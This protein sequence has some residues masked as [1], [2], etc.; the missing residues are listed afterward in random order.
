MKGQGLSITTIVV[1]AIALLVLVVLVAIFTGN[2][3][4]TDK[5]LKSCE[6]TNGVCASE[7]PADGKS[8]IRNPAKD[9][10]CQSISGQED[11]K[12]YKLLEG[13]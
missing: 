10:I 7:K 4:E 2:I 9:A 12:C 8:Y 1:A 3:V 5:V 6:G 13:L 11:F